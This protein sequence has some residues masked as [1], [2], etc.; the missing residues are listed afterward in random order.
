MMLDED[1]EARR[2]A[3]EAVLEIMPKVKKAPEEKLSG[4]F[5]FLSLLLLMAEKGNT[6]KRQKE[7]LR[8]TH[9][10][11]DEDRFFENPEF[12]N[13]CIAVIYETERQLLGTDSPLNGGIWP[14][15]ASDTGLP[16]LPIKY[17][18]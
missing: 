11:A 4:H 16:A 12:R 2:K 8:C 17:R 13:R 7:Y 1:E 5:T 3:E 10:R 15:K 18:R 14:Q 9:A 6:P